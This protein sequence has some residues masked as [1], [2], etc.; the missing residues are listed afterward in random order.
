MMNE[1]GGGGGGGGGEGGLFLFTFI[2]TPVSVKCDTL[3]D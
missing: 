3:A 2:H 1:L